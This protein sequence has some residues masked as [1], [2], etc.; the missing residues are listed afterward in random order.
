M[1]IATCYVLINMEN[2]G[3]KIK[4]IRDSYKLSQ[5]RFGKR[6]GLSGKTISAYE[7]NKATPPLY[8]LE[9]IST[10]YKA[11]IFDL[12]EKDKKDII[13]TLNSMNESIHDLKLF[14]D[15]GL[16]L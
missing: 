15:K 8:V 1:Y 6:L 14:L 4:L 13:E 5:S 7:T 9:R 16:S 10:V 11:N 12:P 3:N 2:I